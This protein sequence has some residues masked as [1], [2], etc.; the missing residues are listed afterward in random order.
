MAAYEEAR[1]LAMRGLDFDTIVAR[2]E[3]DK[4]LDRHSARAAAAKALAPDH[5]PAVSLAA[6]LAEIAAKLDRR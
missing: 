6:E 3:R 4:G 5:A 2:L 1:M